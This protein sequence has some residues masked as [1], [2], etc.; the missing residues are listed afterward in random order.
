MVILD[1]QEEPR[2][3]YLF[4][5]AMT[6]WRQWLVVTPPLPPHPAPTHTQLFFFFLGGGRFSGLD[7]DDIY[8]VILPSCV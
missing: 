8:V 4:F 7:N 5:K 3:T 2:L 6:S 1:W